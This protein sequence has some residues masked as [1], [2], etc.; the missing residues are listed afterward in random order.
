MATK[1]LDKKYFP[2]YRETTD[3][4]GRVLKDPIGVFSCR[5]STARFLDI[6]KLNYNFQVEV[7]RKGGKRSLFLADGTQ[8][9]NS[10]ANTDQAR[11]DS[12]I[13]LSSSPKGSKTVTIRTG[14]KIADTQRKTGKDSAYHTVSFRFPGWATIKVIADA[15]GEIIP[16]GKL[17][18][19]PGETE[20]KNQFKVKG[21]G[22]YFILSKT[23]AENQPD[24]V[25]PETEAEL[26]TVLQKA[27]DNKKATKVS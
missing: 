10:E 26:N 16:A 13:I 11:S 3:D 17:S 5:M 25:V 15:L 2:I 22:T 27:E 12:T 20:V 18:S 8:M 21:G 7:A 23:V 4:A 19:D 6:D 1:S 24:A 9:T 14:K